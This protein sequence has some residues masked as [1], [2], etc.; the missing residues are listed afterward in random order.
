[1]NRV[2]AY[3]RLLKWKM[4]QGNQPDSKIYT[5]LVN[6]EELLTDFNSQPYLGWMKEEGKVK[7]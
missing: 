6:E 3:I 7:S 1:M 5:E 2:K 4:N